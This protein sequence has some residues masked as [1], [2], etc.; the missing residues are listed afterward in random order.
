MRKCV[1]V[2][3][4]ALLAPVLLSRPAAGQAASA[5]QEQVAVQPAHVRVTSRI[6]VVDRE[7]LTRAGLSYVVLG[8]GRVRVDAAGRG[9]A[10][11][12]VRLG[13]HSASAF[14]EAVRSRGWIRSESTQ[15]V[16]TMSGR[17]A[18]VSSNSLTLDR[19][20][21]RRRGPSLVVIP[22]VLPAGQVQLE[23]SARIEDDVT[24]RWGYG[25]DGSPA[26]VDT[27]ITAA[28]GEEIIV[29]SSSVVETARESGLLRWGTS[30]RGRDV[31]VAV[32]AQV[33]VR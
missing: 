9:A 33:V 4:V 12:G 27:E 6:V 31:L 32:T 8:G 14:L 5:G 13:T 24:Y 3:L 20:A 28:D 18:V 11:D 7:A 30:E 19:R 10:S 23:L 29:G 21:A 16:L 26:A 22:T 15:Q 17:E 2:G 1:F 25:V